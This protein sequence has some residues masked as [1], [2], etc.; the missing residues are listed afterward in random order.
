M[1]SFQGY[2]K[3]LI[4]THG[5][6]RA[7]LISESCL[8]SSKNVPNTFYYDE[9]QWYLDKEGGLSLAK[10]QKKYSGI[11]ERRLNKTLNFW[12]QV[13]AIIKKEAKNA[14]A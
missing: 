14:V 4:S 2:A 12:T 1:N 8:A 6:E 10:D 13:H 9:A 7:L 11:K 5:I 3:S